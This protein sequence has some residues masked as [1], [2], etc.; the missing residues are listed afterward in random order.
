MSYDIELGQGDT[1]SIGV[2]LKENG[3]GANL[4]SGTVVFSMKNDMGT[5]EYD[6]TCIPGATIDGVDVLFSEG[7]VTIP[8]TDTHTSSPGTFFGIFHVT[9][10]GKQTTFPSSENISVKIKKTL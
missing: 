10:L 1:D 3:T 5:I 9:I 4:T 2:V 6:I 7:G 8:F